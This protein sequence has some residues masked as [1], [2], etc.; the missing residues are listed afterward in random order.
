MGGRWRGGLGSY[1]RT[2]GPAEREGART[3]G[4]MDLLRGRALLA[5]YRVRPRSVSRSAR[6]RGGG[7]VAGRKKKAESLASGGTYSLLTG[8]YV[9]TNFTVRPP[10]PPA[11]PPPAAA[12]PAAPAEP[13]AEKPK[14][15]VSRPGPGQT[16]PAQ[17]EPDEEI[18]TRPLTCIP[19]SRLI[20][21]HPAV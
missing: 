11:G 10:A 8:P 7:E 2:D 3:D 18:N 17:G 4:R 1:G 16:N 20:R 19:L 9:P 6:P 21:V 13:E 14:A 15:P 12:A 5:V